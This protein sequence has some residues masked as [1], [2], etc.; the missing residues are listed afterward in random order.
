MTWNTP[1]NVS[2]GNALTALLWNNLLGTSGSLQYVYNEL[3][4]TQLKRYVTLYKSTNTV[5]AAAGTTNIAFDTIV[6]S[7]SG[8]QQDFPITTP[9]TNIPIPAKGMYLATYQLRSTAAVVVR[10]NFL[11]QNGADARFFA[12]HQTPTVNVLFTDMCLFYAPDSLG[13]FTVSTQV[14]ATATITAVAHSPT[15]GSQILT[16]TRI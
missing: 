4:T 1:T 8:Q 15:D 13:T 6:T 3:T 11:Y 16:I 10:T 14:S 9:I 7:Y 12:N 5:F 2:T